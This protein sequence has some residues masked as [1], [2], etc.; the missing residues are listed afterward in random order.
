MDRVSARRVVGATIPMLVCCTSAPPNHVTTAELRGGDYRLIVDD[1][2]T[3]RLLRVDDELVRFERDGLRLGLAAPVDDVTN[4][5]PYRLFVP[6]GLY[7]PP[8][9]STFVEVESATFVP[10]EA[11]S[12]RLELRYP[13]GRTATL[14]AQVGGD[15]RFALSFIPRD[16][17]ADVAYLDARARADADEGFY[18][19]GEMSD[20]VNQRGKVRAMQIE[21]ETTNESGY[22]DGHAPVPLVIGTR[23]W[24]MFVETRLPA[25]FALATEEPTL[26]EAAVGVGTRAREG[27]ALHLF[28]A[29]HPLDVPRRYF[30]VTGLPGL[31]A[32]WALGPWV[33]RDENDDQAQVEADLDALRD[34]DLATTGYWLDR[35]YASGVNTFD[36]EPKRFPDPQGMLDKAR[37]LGLRTALWHVPYLDTKDPSTAP[38]VAEAKSKGFYPTQHGIALNPW[39]T[40]LDLT[41]PA[42]VAWWQ[43]QLSSYIAMG[44]DGFKLDYAEDIVLGPTANR[45]AW[46]FFDGSDERTQHSE[47]QLR[48]HRTYAELLP[49]SGGFLL[50][51]AARWGD[52]VHGM[53]M[54]P[55]DLDATFAKRNDA[56]KDG[57]TSYV[58][59]GGFPASLVCGLTLSTVGYPFYGADTGGYRHAPPDNELFSRWFEQ[60]ALSTVMQV[61]T[62][63]NDVAWEPTPKNGFDTALLERY[64]AYARLHLRLFPYLWTHAER[65]RL[66]GR[67][68]MR[69]LGLAHPELGVHPNDIYLLGDDLLVAPVVTRGATSREVLFPAGRWVHWFTGEVF[70]GDVLGGAAVTVAAPIGRL[71]LFLRAGGLVPMLR[72]SIDTLSPTSEPS[73]VDSYATD[74]GLLY[75]RGV[76]RISGAFTLFDGGRLAAHTK[77]S[78][79]ELEVLGGTELAQGA[80]FE[81]LDA[82]APTTVEASAP[83]TQR[84][85]VA[86][87]AAKGGY[88]YDAKARSLHVLVRPNAPVKVRWP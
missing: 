28:G 13:E 51:R 17:A 21:V 2:P 88:L 74:S 58:A 20:D 63:T 68:I 8:V 62:N 54:W 12:L 43:D 71:P 72:P 35:P 77:D 87:V 14:D 36:F 7:R 26:V 49:E 24:G 42:A 27:I 23:G 55:G 22:N 65:V 45:V 75:V 69:A 44:I 81:L 15:G 40:L 84:G 5:D 9:E 70:D 25:A 50:T 18:G 4:Y 47:F 19:L 53:V 56:M 85:D 46:S 52:H 83:V 82:D 48:Y 10:S 3:L 1:R 41:N 76:A 29:E 86:E 80:V 61:G 31:P 16:G 64:R 11:G 66:D 73:R 30:D 57:D 59:T 78:V 33:W 60:T 32:R 38:L 34:L 6:S 79:T 39:G 37:A 67:P